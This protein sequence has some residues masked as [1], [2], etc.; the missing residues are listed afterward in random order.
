MLDATQPTRP[1]RI[2]ARSY[3]AFVLAPKPPIFAWLNDLDAW[4]KRSPGFFA[5]KPVVLDV[6]DLA[7]GPPGIAQVI[8]EMRA[9]DIRVM[10]VEGT[11]L[12]DLGPDL[13]PIL[14]SARGAG[15]PTAADA[16]A[17]ETAS[18]SSGASEP[19]S[20]VLDGPVRSGQSIVF[21]GDVTVLGSVASGAEIIAGGSIH[22][23]GALRGRALAG[24]NGN[25]R[26]RIFCNKVDAELLAINGFYRIADDIDP[27]L[28]SR[29][30]QVWL[31]GEMMLIAPLN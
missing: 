17:Q 13:P 6:G 21:P 29:P 26:A 1:A 11:K 8:A 16:A 18:A 24:S 31:Q 7:L 12:T 28:R 4:I 25:S 20:L 9:F 3:L 22:V 23:Y 30:I 10:G 14:T 27:S 5:G 15:T 2:L 19:E